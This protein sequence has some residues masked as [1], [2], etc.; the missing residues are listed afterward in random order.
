MQ[1]G[2]PPRVCRKMRHRYCA[3]QIFGNRLH[4]GQTFQAGQPVRLAVD[5]SKILNMFGF[6][7]CSKL[8]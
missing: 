1:D 8:A 2:Q 6:R 4:L 5:V 7:R 3:A